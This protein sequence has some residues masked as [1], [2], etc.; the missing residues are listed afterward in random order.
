MRVLIAGCGYLGLAL[1]ARLHSEGHTVHGVRRTE[2][3]PTPLRAA[4]IVPIHA[5]LTLPSSLTSLAGPAW[6]AVVLCAAPREGTEPAYRSLYIEGTRNLVKWFLHSGEPT[7]RRLVFTGSTSV[8][9]QTDGSPVDESSPTE[10]ADFGGRILLETESLLAQAALHGLSTTVL[11]VAGIYGPR[12]NRLAAFRRGESPI[13]FDGQRWMNLVHRD[14]LVSA[15]FATIT[16]GT[17]GPVYNVSDG[18]PPSEAEFHAWIT[19]R[20]G[21]PALPRGHCHSAPATPARR[22]RTASHKQVLNHRIRRDLGWSPA[23]PDFKAGY[24]H[25]LAS[26]E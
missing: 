11:R 15:V 12:R 25:L 20:L 16:A 13:R 5:D 19:G 18:R 21:L 1:G 23:F 7:P 10:P 2:S 26:G 4:G 14:D 9:A 6:D 3:D 24:D 17:P 8:Y 22:R